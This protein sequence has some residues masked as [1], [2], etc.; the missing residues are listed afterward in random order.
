MFAGIIVKF[1]K[2]FSFCLTGTISAALLMP[3]RLHRN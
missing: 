2:Y 1:G 3:G